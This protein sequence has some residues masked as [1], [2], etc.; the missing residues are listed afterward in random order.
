VVHSLR[1]QLLYIYIYIYAILQFLFSYVESDRN[2]VISF[3]ELLLKFVFYLFVFVLCNNTFG[4]SVVSND[5]NRRMIFCDCYVSKNKN[6]FL[7]LI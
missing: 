5:G 4:T 6:L 2:S 7:V 3:V 1:N